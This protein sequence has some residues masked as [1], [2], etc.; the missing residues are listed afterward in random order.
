[1]TVTATK[2][3]PSARLT[4]RKLAEIVGRNPKTIRKYMVRGSQGIL[5]QSEW[6]IGLRV[7]CLAWWE[8]FRQKVGQER[9]R[10]R[11]ARLAELERALDADASERHARARKKLEERGLV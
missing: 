8:S 3:D 2:T 6:D 5:L 11:Q 10:R 9:E 1:M 4:A 7:T